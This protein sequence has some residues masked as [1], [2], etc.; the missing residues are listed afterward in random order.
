MVVTA[1]VV[2]TS[3]ASAKS[4]LFSNQDRRFLPAVFVFM[5]SKALAAPADCVI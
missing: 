4:H 1:H 5:G 2:V 3:G